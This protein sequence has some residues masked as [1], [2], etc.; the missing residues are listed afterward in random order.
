MIPKRALL[1]G[2]VG[3]RPDGAGVQADFEDTADRLSLRAAGD[4][5]GVVAGP[6]NLR[7]SPALLPGAR[8]PNGRRIRRPFD[9]PTG[10]GGPI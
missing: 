6:H 5:V 7:E 9:S 10:C 2:D 4:G 8:K 3:L 1:L